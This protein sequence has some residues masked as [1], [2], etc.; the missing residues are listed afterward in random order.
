MIWVLPTFPS[1]TAHMSPSD[2]V[3]SHISQLCP[4]LTYLEGCGM[5]YLR[6]ASREIL[7]TARP[8]LASVPPCF[9]RG[10]RL[11]GGGLD[12]GVTYRPAFARAREDGPNWLGVGGRECSVLVRC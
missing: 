5:S 12:G 2:L 10:R 6:G 9:V 11:G 7:H 1:L 3:I 4:R 8:C